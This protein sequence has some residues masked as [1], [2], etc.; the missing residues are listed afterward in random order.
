MSLD[1]TRNILNSFLPGSVKSQDL[2][3]ALVTT[4]CA[5]PQPSNE[6]ALEYLQEDLPVETLYNEELLKGPTTLFRVLRDYLVH[7]GVPYHPYPRNNRLA[8]GIA[9]TFF[10]GEDQEKAFQILMPTRSQNTD[11]PTQ[12][13]NQRTQTTEFITTTN[14][15]EDSER[16]AAVSV[17]QQYKNN[18]DRFKG[19]LGEDIHQYIHNYETICED[20][21]LSESQKLKFLHYLFAD[22]AKT[23]FDSL[24]ISEKDT[25]E[26]ATNSVIKQFDTKTKQTRVRQYLQSLTLTEIV[27]NKSCTISDGLEELRST[28]SKLAPQGPTAH[29]T[30]EAK[31][32]YMYNAVLQHEWASTVL[33]SCYTEDSKMTFNKLCNALD[34]AYLQHQNRKNMSQNNPGS[35]SMHESQIFWE[36][37]RFYGK[38]RGKNKFMNKFNRKPFCH[39]CKKKGHWT[40]QCPLKQGNLTRNVY[41]EVAQNPKMAK[42]ILFELCYSHDILQNENNDSAESEDNDDDTNEDD[43]LET[44]FV[45]NL[46]GKN[47]DSD[48]DS[49]DF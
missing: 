10:S 35:S 5:E 22:E 2:K 18:K 28:I 34:S 44:N 46:L 9:N 1:H 30:E 12:P 14:N 49:S 39:N 15:K 24:D 42:K 13:N 47:S 33:N 4:I 41:A 8:F 40:G 38:P 16:K 21:K 19:K 23:F 31:I 48:S 27:N 17:S 3:A 45:Q 37:Q 29:R 6:E 7:I 32:D 36:N 11:T 43:Q 26:K 20:Y 25:F